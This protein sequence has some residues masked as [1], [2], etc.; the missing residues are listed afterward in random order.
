MA[1]CNPTP[2]LSVFPF[3]TAAT[4]TTSFTLA[5]QTQPDGSVST[6]TLPRII[7]SINALGNQ[8][9]IILNAGQCFKLPGS[10]DYRYKYHFPIHND[11]PT[12]TLD[13]SQ[14]LKLVKP[15]G[16]GGSDYRHKYHFPIHNGTP[17]TIL[18][19]GH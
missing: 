3:M 13:A 15:Y 1:S 4:T 11:T 7:T 19:A 14:W 9:S 12:I 16:P 10:S 17:T 5:L 2:Y 8:T 18:D 6:V